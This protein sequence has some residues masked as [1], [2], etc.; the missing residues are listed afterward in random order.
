MFRLVDASVPP[1]VILDFNNSLLSIFDARLFSFLSSF[2]IKT[3]K[4]HLFGEPEANGGGGQRK[5]VNR[6]IN[7]LG[8]LN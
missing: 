1:P 7:R 3:Q 2:P 6:K 8:A 5:K 4:I